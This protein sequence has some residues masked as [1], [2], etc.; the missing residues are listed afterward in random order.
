MIDHVHCSTF[1][2]KTAL[3]LWKQVLL[4][5]FDETA[6]ENPGKDVPRYEEE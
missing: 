2:T 6:E 5:V 4:E 3:T 1:L